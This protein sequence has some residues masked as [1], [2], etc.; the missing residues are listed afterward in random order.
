MTEGRSTPHALASG[1]RQ[2]GVTDSEFP[3]SSPGTDGGA[4]QSGCPA[5]P[6]DAPA[7]KLCYG[8][9]NITVSRLKGEA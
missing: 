9:E 7:R 4:P 1:S 6:H 2:N 3:W 8:R 5:T